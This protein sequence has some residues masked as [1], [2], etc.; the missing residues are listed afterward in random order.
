[1]AR[2]LSFWKYKKNVVADDAEVYA[3]LSE[4]G[5]KSIYIIDNNRKKR[6]KDMWTM[7]ELMFIIGVTLVGCVVGGVVAVA[8][9]LVKN[10]KNKK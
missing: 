9:Q 5:C 2:D 10:K 4:L 3:K 1:M 6:G 7:N 8:I